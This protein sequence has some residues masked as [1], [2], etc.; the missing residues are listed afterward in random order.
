MNLVINILRTGWIHH[1]V[2][3]NMELAKRYEALHSEHRHS[4]EGDIAL[5][6]MM[7]YKDRADSLIQ[8]MR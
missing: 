3:R 7:K 6:L 8:S 1:Q 2:I 5:R 4:V